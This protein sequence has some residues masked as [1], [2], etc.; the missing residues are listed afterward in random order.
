MLRFEAPASGDFTLVT[1]DL[2]KMRALNPS[3]VNVMNRSLLAGA[4]VLAVVCSAPALAHVDVGIAV[5]IPG[6]DVG[7]PGVVV[8][9]PPAYYP[10]VEYVAPPPPPVVVVPPPGPAYAP[11]YGWVYPGDDED[12]GHWRRRPHWHGH[13]WHRGGDDDD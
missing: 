11:Y 1:G 4:A 9:P 3:Q 5:G 6:F 2:A 8:A 10:P 7:V 13:K 12:E